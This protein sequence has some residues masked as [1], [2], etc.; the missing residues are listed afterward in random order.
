MS[1][2]ATTSMSPRSTHRRTKVR[3]I[4][5]K[6][7]IPTRVVM[8]YPSWAA[9]LA[10][11]G[12]CAAGLAPGAVAP[13]PDHDRYRPPR[14]ATGIGHQ[15]PGPSALSEG[16]LARPVGNGTR[17]A[18]EATVECPV[19]LGFL[20]EPGESG[21]LLGPRLPRPWLQATTAR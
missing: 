17:E 15:L 6:P 20:A 5:P 12:C 7:L 1:L 4:L 2:I 16:R 3:P 11:G 14:R 18:T 9:G 8:C 19:I 10:P 13:P 21:R